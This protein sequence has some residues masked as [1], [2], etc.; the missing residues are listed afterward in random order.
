MRK[1]NV[2]VKCTFMSQEQQSASEKVKRCN[3]KRIVVYKKVYSFNTLRILYN[4]N[5]VRIFLSHF[6]P[7]FVLPY[8]VLYFFCKQISFKSCKAKTV[9]AGAR[10]N[11]VQPAKLSCCACVRLCLRRGLSAFMLKPLTIFA[12]QHHGFR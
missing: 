7:F 10:I 11:A 4:K 5:L 2:V 9:G 1:A 12:Y 6:S 8:F 3:F